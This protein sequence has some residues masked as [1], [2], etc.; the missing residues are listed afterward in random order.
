[1]YLIQLIRGSY[2]VC[3][4]KGEAMIHTSWYPNPLLWE[5]QLNNNN[6]GTTKLH[7]TG[8]KS[9]HFVVHVSPS[10]FDLKRD[11]LAHYTQKKFNWAVGR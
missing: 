4:G 6:K 10:I 5:G 11:K 8:E 3:I 7:K 9:T 1:M 2:L